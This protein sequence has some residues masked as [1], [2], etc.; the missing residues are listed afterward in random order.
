MTAMTTSSSIKVKARN[1]EPSGPLPFCVVGIV[2]FIELQ[3]SGRV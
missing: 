3:M 2:V 1:R